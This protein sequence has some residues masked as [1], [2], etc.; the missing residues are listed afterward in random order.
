MGIQVVVTGVL[1]K[2]P[3]ARTSQN[4][5]PYATCNVRVEQDGQT[6]WANVICFNEEA[7]EELLRLRNGD[8]LSVHGKAIP[9]VYM[10]DDEA[11]PTLHVTASAVHSLQ[12]PRDPAFMARQEAQPPRAPARPRRAARPKPAAPV[13]ERLADEGFD[14]PLDF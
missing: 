11:R 5:N 3:V 14:D 1:H 13:G 9:K 12:P 8:L 10:K 2:D 4:G 6:H 7:L